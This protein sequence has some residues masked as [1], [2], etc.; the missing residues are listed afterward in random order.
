MRWKR[1]QT[2]AARSWWH[3]QNPSIN[4]RLG[5]RQDVWQIVKPNMALRRL[6]L[7]NKKDFSSTLSGDVK[8]THEITE[9]SLSYTSKPSVLEQSGR[10]IEVHKIYDTSNEQIE[11]FFK[12]FCD[13][14]KSANY[15]E[16]SM[17]ESLQIVYP[18]LKQESSYSVL[19]QIC[20]SIVCIKK[21][22][23]TDQSNII[24]SMLF[25]SKRILVQKDSLLC[26]RKPYYVS[27]HCILY[28]LNI[29]FVGISKFY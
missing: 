22:L 7:I 26:Q 13:V 16:F 6:I 21:R 17:L 10:A 28:W 14:I 29:W 3:Y 24:L 11:I 4:S 19:E 15:M 8:L 23:K 25:G 2:I 18:N 12:F 5:L 9:I 1:K 27:F 20:W